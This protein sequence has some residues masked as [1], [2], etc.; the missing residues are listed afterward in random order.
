MFAEELWQCSIEQ[1]FS[2]SKRNPCWN[3]VLLKC[4]WDRPTYWWDRV[5]TAQWPDCKDAFF[6]RR[7]DLRIQD[8]SESRGISNIFQNQRPGKK[9]SKC[10]IQEGRPTDFGA[11]TVGQ[12]TYAAVTVVLGRRSWQTFERIAGHC[13]FCMMA[14]GNTGDDAISY[15]DTCVCSCIAQELCA[16]LADFG[17]SKR[18]GHHSFV[19]KRKHWFCCWNIF[20]PSEDYKA[21]ASRIHEAAWL[22]AHPVQEWRDVIPYAQGIHSLDGTRGLT[23]LDHIRSDFFHWKRKVSVWFFFSWVHSTWQGYAR[24]M[25]NWTF[26][27]CVQFICTLSIMVDTAGD[28]NAFPMHDQFWYT[29]YILS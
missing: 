19:R 16:K 22:C 6:L 10:F 28:F 23:W 27:T 26:F 18:T 12:R 2:W 14:R 15:M 24:M 13:R 25:C 3:L 5:Q 17:C 8:E 29:H 1:H 11:V 21:M 4:R 9:T 7:D 20:K